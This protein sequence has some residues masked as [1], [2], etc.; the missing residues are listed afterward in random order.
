MST[1]D[2]ENESD[3][4]AN[5]GET[6]SALSPSNSDQKKEDEVEEIDFSTP[7]E[8]HSLSNSP[9]VPTLPSEIPASQPLPEKIGRFIVRS[10]LGM[11]GFADVFLALDEKLGRNVAI[12]MPRLDKWRS[13]A[14]IPLFV[15]EAQTSAK[16][17]HPGIVK[18]YDVGTHDGRP[19]IVLEY[20]RGRSLAELLEEEPIATSKAVR[21]IIQVAEA[22]TQAHDR[23]FVHRDIKPQNILLDVDD[24]PHIADFGL[25]VKLWEVEDDMSLAGTT[26]YMAPEQVRGESHRIDLRTDIWAMGVVLYRMLTGKLPFTGSTRKEIYEGI[27]YR[28]PVLPTE[29]DSRIPKELERICLRCLS[30]QMSDRYPRA[31]ELADDL[32]EWQDLTGGGSGRSTG[33]TGSRRRALAFIPPP[34]APVIPRGLRSFEPEDGDFFLRLLP[35]PRD[36]DGLPTSIRFW[37][38]RI[39]NRDNEQTFGIGVLCGPSGCGKSSLVKAGLLPNLNKNVA[40]IRLEASPDSTADRLLKFVN[41]ISR[42]PLHAKTVDDAFRILRGSEEL[43]GGR[44]LLIVIDQFEQWLGTW[45]GSD[46]DHLVAALRQC[47]GG[48]IQ[49]ILMVRDDYS[50]ELSRLMKTLEVAVIDGVNG[51]IVDSFDPEHA[52]GVMRELGQAYNRLPQGTALTQEQQQFIDQSVCGLTENNRLYPVRLAAFVEMVKDRPWHPETL[53]IMGGTKGVGVAFL[54]AT[55]GNQASSSR[56]LHS[57]VIRR[58]LTVL[59]PAAGDINDRVLLRSEL[60]AAAQYT[61][62]PHDFDTVM[63][64]LDIELR[65]ITSAQASQGA[66]VNE[67]QGSDSSTSDTSNIVRGDGGY[68]LT[69]DFLIPSIREWLQRQNCASRKGRILMLLQEQSQIWSSRPN[70]RFLPTFSEWLSI[71][72]QTSRQEW[73]QPQRLMMQ[74]ATRRIYSRTLRLMATLCVALLI[75][76]LLYLPTARYRSQIE[77]STL[78]SQLKQVDLAD[79]PEALNRLEPYRPWADTMLTKEFNNP[80]LDIQKKL[81]VAIARLPTER[82]CA[83]WLAEMMLNEQVAASDWPM[84]L[85]TLSTYKDL[86]LP[87]WEAKLD[88][89]SPSIR[90]RALLAFWSQTQDKTFWESHSHEIVSH[91]LQLPLAESAHWLKALKPAASGLRQ[92]I[93]DMWSEIKDVDQAKVACQTLTS[94]A[95]E[96]IADLLKLLEGSTQVGY[97]AI[98]DTLKSKR[99][100]SQTFLKNHFDAIR[101]ANPTELHLANVSLALWELGDDSEFRRAV[102]P[103]PDATLRTRILQNLSHESGPIGGLLSIVKQADVDDP[104]LCVTLAA[105]AVHPQGT[106]AAVTKEEIRK[107]L[108]VIYEQTNNSEIHS[109]AGLLLRRLGLDWKSLDEP[110]PALSAPEGNKKWYK[111]PSG[112]TMAIVEPS[113]K[114]AN[115]PGDSQTINH[116]LAVSTTEITLAFY[117]RYDREYRA[118]E[119]LSVDSDETPV[120]GLLLVEVAGFCNWLS[121]QENIAPDQWCYPPADKLT[122]SNC[123][124]YPD[125]QQRQ[126]YRLM[127][128]KEWDAAVG[129]G[130]ITQRFFGDEDSA[131]PHYAWTQVQSGRLMHE[132]GKLLPNPHGLFDVYGNAREMVMSDDEGLAYDSPK[133]EARGG[134][135]LTGDHSLTTSARISR[136]HRSRDPYLGLRVVRSII[137]NN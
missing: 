57:A 113:A 95:P 133:L 9:S 16:L 41:K 17:D 71:Q 40:Y 46:E 124:P 120:P 104:C 52:R 125:A 108:R 11:G 83:S 30:R 88:S 101:S 58:I 66:L 33:D 96:N 74:A 117:E 78:V 89:A 15:Q 69:H 79:L 21:L 102:Q 34:D 106:S 64:I 73:T 93:L 127:Y 12:K 110:I 36:R 75:A 10:R 115:L 32:R 134:A 111:S 44:K 13:K 8:T 132:V 97:R 50:F 23:G 27:L 105:L 85:N 54:D 53:K 56:R 136:D 3:R 114:D 28:L 126:G 62:R 72:W 129:A 42:E 55:V 2:D 51:M 103:G 4:S 118:A 35:G 22:I 109:T 107:R 43:R 123:A 77:A 25:A 112:L 94:L 1:G 67:S 135:S 14:E 100:T 98:V 29:L 80:D 119:A 92:T 131:L 39:E 76:Y 47:D 37:K 70:P 5:D 91:Y 61:N 63:R 59:L 68:K 19:Y 87:V 24:N 82:S 6:E 121:K 26:H 99:E 86:T 128:G 45:S 48:N 90:F 81:R 65:L 31:A 18:V 84:L 122:V 137:K 130:A 38:G 7:T 49:A 20:I 60:L 116:S